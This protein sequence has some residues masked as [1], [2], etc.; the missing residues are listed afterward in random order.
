MEFSF[1]ILK[2]IESEFTK[3][4]E[5]SE[6]DRKV[7]NIYYPRKVIDCLLY[8]FEKDSLTSCLMGFDFM[9]YVF[10]KAHVDESDDSFFKYKINRHGDVWVGFVA[11]E[12]ELVRICVKVDNVYTCIFD[13]KVQAGEI[14][15]PFFNTHMLPLITMLNSE[16]YINTSH[17][18]PLFCL[19]TS[20]KEKRKTL[21][22]QKN[23]NYLE[24]KENVY[25]IDHGRLYKIKKS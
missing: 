20:K 11:T 18:I 24:D 16:I 5:K 13:D 14:K 23:L 19:V 12:D 6:C 1:L 2:E 10:I 4:L 3:R 17:V 15:K 8:T 21:G 9:D 22:L 7:T 25:N